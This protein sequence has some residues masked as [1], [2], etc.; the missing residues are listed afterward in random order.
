M[1]R[2]WM[3]I[4]CAAAFACLGPNTADATHGG[5]NAANLRTAINL[6]RDGDLQADWN[7]MLDARDQFVALAADPSVAALAHYYIGYTYWRLSSLAYVAIGL[8]AQAQLV[9]RAVNSLETAVKLRPEFPDAHALLA[10]CLGI[11][12]GGDRSRV[13]SLAP[14]MRGAAQAA[15]PAGATNPR[16]MLMRAMSMAF[17]PPEYGGDREKGIELWKQAIAAFEKDRPEALMPD[18][19][20]AEA[21]AWMGGFHLM[22]N[23]HEEAVPFLERAVGLRPDFWW[24]GKAALPIARRPVN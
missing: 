19:G 17:A 1:T 7:K 21:L 18:W 11:L 6:A 9:D 24:A 13:E 15:Q 22:L 2:H 8:K 4:I 23:Q 12:I 16:V 5:D 20:H 14:R 3:L 10:T